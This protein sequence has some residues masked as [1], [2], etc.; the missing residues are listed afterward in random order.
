MI[1]L[2]KLQTMKVQSE[3]EEYITIL[4]HGTIFR[5]PKKLKENNIVIYSKSNINNFISIYLKYDKDNLFSEWK[6]V[7]MASINSRIYQR[8]MK[9][10]ESWIE[11]NT[12]IFSYEEKNNSL[13]LCF[14]NFHFIFEM[15]DDQDWCSFQI[16]ILEPNG[17]LFSEFCLSYVIKCINSF[18]TN[19][20]SF[21]FES[22]NPVFKKNGEYNSISR[23]PF[24]LVHSFT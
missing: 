18:K 6:M 3:D 10:E 9:V 8:T 17:K 12:N 13:K 14:G 22:I 15:T 23:E 24:M 2:E 1:I 4:L 19:N 20:P 5:I 7:F 21:H 11:N 16:N